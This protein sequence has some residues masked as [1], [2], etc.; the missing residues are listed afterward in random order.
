MINARLF[1]DLANL[2]NSHRTIVSDGSSRV[3][4]VLKN[5]FIEGKVLEFESGD[6]KSGWYIPQEWQLKKAELREHASGALIYSNLNSPL[7]IAPYSQS[8]E[9]LLDKNGLRELITFSESNPDALRYQHRLAYDPRRNMK[10]VSI[11]IPKSLFDSLSDN[12]LYSLSV[13]SE[14]KPGSMKIFD[15]TIPGICN[16]SVLLLSHV[17][18]TGQ[19]ND[20]LAGVLVMS[21]VADNLRKRRNLLKYSYS[22]LAFPETIGSSVYLYEHSN[23]L[24]SA[25]FTIFSEMPGAYGDLR[26]AQTRRGNS[27]IDR[28]ASH[29]LK[30][31]GVKYT[32]VEFRNGWGNDEMVFD[33]VFSG[34]PSIS[35]DRAPFEHYHLS[36]DTLGNSS[37]VN[38]YKVVNI[39]T[40]ICLLL[41][42]DYIPFPNFFV[43]PQ[44][45][46]L[47]LYKDWTND[48]AS[49]DQ[50]SLLLDEL[51]SG[52]SVFDI[53][54]SSSIPFE[55][56]LNFYN[57]LG[58]HSL[59]EKRNISASYTRR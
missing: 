7:F 57:T 54:Y 5:F 21:M 19:W 24:E 51:P 43:T 8:A 48:R 25:L 23:L 13:K 39:V 4:D 18:H 28:L 59:I 14:I 34:I 22:L 47:G 2:V 40:E 42:S 45:S 12:H 55:D 31:R 58:D 44:L 29:V 36:T 27:Y 35:I 10:E 52:K 20:G 11:S 33:S 50:T 49:Y 53:A 9:L 15:L 17:C 41:E 6:H 26:V 1:L 16:E 32:S 30:S 37:L 46:R 38:L 56:A 3:V